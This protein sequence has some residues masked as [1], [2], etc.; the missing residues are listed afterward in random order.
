MKT[1]SIGIIGGSGLYDLDNLSNF[2]EHI[3]NT[4][5]GVPSDPIITGT[6]DGIPVAF[7]SR[8]GKGHRL[9]PSKIPFRANVYALKTLGVKYLLSVSAVGSLRESIKPLDIVLP[10][11][12]LDF[13][14]NRV[15]TFFDEGVVA[16]ISMA[17]PV[18]TTLSSIVKK[19]IEN[20][21]KEQTLQV[22]DNK[23]YICI[24]GPQFSTVA[25]S[26]Y[27]RLINA[28]V[29]GMT[30]MPEAKLALEA[31]MA[32]CSIAFVTDFDCWHPKEENVSVS[33]A[34]ENLHKNIHLAKIIIQESIHNIHTTL[35]ATKA[36]HSLKNAIVTELSTLNTEYKEII[37]VLLA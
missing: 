1:F 29:I 14:K 11:Q 18:C 30:N 2:Q 33:L 10:S 24:E 31:Q 21:I 34:I 5:F 7:L 19:S 35:P 26:N 36:H 32:Y 25:E 12:Y 3:I 22:H 16:H 8:H 15:S 37:D 28:D 6:I 17:E 13:T 27:Y 4:P 20:V 9:I 23:T